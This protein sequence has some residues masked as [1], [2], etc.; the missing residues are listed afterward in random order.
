MTDKEWEERQKTRQEEM[1]AVSEALS[2]LS[3][4]DARH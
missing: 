1:Q 4:D 3:S 2:V